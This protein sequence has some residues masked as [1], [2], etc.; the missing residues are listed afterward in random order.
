MWFVGASRFKGFLCGPGGQEKGYRGD[1]QT[2]QEV[3]GSLC[4]SEVCI[5]A[6]S[7]TF[8]TPL[9]KG[10]KVHMRKTQ[11]SHTHTCMNTCA[12]IHTMISAKHSN[13]IP[14]PR[15]TQCGASTQASRYWE[16]ARDTCSW[17]ITVFKEICSERWGP[18]QF[19]AHLQAKCP[20][21]VL[22]LETVIRSAGKK[23][24]Q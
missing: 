7:S 15:D 23:V 11:A 8:I 10:T 12:L 13:L 22:W 9:S 21:S 24:P 18:C 4:V 1:P 14:R 19:V 5:S 6:L 3:I 17:V 16:K 20:V 2:P